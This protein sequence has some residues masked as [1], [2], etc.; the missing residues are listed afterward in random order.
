[1]S[2]PIEY[3]LSLVTSQYS[4]S[5][6]F[7]TWLLKAISTVNDNTITANQMIAAFD[8]DTAIGAQLDI[9]GELVGRKRMVNFEPLDGSS[10]V[11]DDT[12][13]RVL[14]KA[15]IVQNQWK[16]TI[17]EL[18]STWKILFPDGDIIITDNQDMS[19]N[20]VIS[21]NLTFLTRDLIRN[22]YIV[23]KPQGVKIN[24]YFGETQ[25]FGYDI[26]NQYIA[27]YDHGEWARTSDEIANFSYDKD[28]SIF[29][30]YDQGN[31][32]N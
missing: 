29:K 13:Y 4:N 22:G 2:K 19:M 17:A 3:Y 18:T 24:Y 1:M 23:P 10:F 9:I 27:G 7:K 31:W 32:S 28:E 26:E 16:G 25:F 6:N 21:G 15:K 5:T 20:V 11:L 8:V 12:N 14:I 30:G